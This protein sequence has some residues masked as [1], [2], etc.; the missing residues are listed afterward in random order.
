MNQKKRAH[1]VVHTHWD[2]SWYWPMERFRVKLVSC[3]KAVVQELRQN[4]DYQFTFDGQVLM[5]ED[6][7]EVCPEDGETLRQAAR[8]GRIR[9]GPLYCLA[10]VY[11]TGGEALIRNLL[12]GKEWCT[13]FG[14]GY[15]R[16]LHM[17]DTFG[18]TPSM[19]MIAAGF[20]MTAFS[21]MR[22]VAGQVPE[23][24]SMREVATG[25]AQIPE[26]TRFFIWRCRDGSEVV[27]I[28]FRHGY[29]SAAAIRHYDP[30][31]GEIRSADYV[32]RLR[33]A[34][35]EW[36]DPAHPVVLLMAGTDHMVPWA[37]Q[38][39]AMGEASREGAYEFTF[40]NLDE[41]AEELR[42][43]DLNALPRYLG[44]F[45]G[46]GAAS[47]LGGTLSARP[48]LKQKNAEV[49][50]ILVH[51]VEPGAA[52]ARL[53][54]RPDESCSLIRQAWKILL[55]THPHDDIC[56]CS[57]DAVHR[58]NESDL[59][60]ARQCADAIRRQVFLQIA[61]HYG[62]N[63]A[64][65]TRPSFGL[66]NFQAREHTGP[67]RLR[68]D[69][70]GMVNWGDLTLPPAYRVVD[71]SGFA[72]PFREVWRG[73]SDEHPRQA[74]DLEVYA[75]LP[76]FAFRRF[77]LEPMGGPMAPPLFRRD[78][79]PLAA[80]NG[81]LEV[82]LH[83]NGTFDLSDL[84][85]GRQAHRL[86][87]LSSQGDIGDS[88]D[89]S[90][91]PEEAEWRHE[92]LAWT[93]SRREWPGGVVELQAAG[94]IELPAWTDAA[95]RTRSKDKVTLPFTQ[96]LILAP[97]ARQLEVRLEFTNTVADYRLR[98]NLSLPPGTRHSL[99]GLKFNTV[100]RPAGSPPSGTTAPR[101]FPEHPADH[102]VAAHT[103]A[104]FSRFP[105]NYELVTD[106][107]GRQR[108]ALTILR[109]FS[110]LTNPH[111]GA[112]R[113]GTHAGP[114]T[115]TPEGRC[116]GRHFRLAFGLC[117]L[118]SADALDDVFQ[119]ALQWRAHPLAGQ[120]DATAPFPWRQADGAPDAP[121]PIQ[122]EGPVVVSAFKPASTGR[123]AVLRL[124]NPS[125]QACNAVVSA[126]D[127][128]SLHPASLDEAPLA[129]PA[130][131]GVCRLT[132][133]PMGLATILL[134]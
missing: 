36:D 49:E 123:G 24:H 50:Q 118:P 122:I 99:A 23:P 71:D 16:V 102:F 58:Q 113:P 83:P 43:T 100:Q 39:A 12:I 65:D 97:G 37:G 26:G 77:Y 109:S 34:A 85:T 114:H 76:P 80:S 27:T 112:T 42:R 95:S 2:R 69:F 47:V 15:S 132:V 91:I 64:G 61:R 32:E 101:I 3:V 104:A 67:S 45:H 117:L 63:A 133:P 10:D 127:W 14:G 110:Y 20:G 103:V 51:Q 120:C 107:D 59:E 52:L 46:A 90:D 55:T 30:T 129:E 79:L 124:L 74:V 92:D 33:Q 125:L 44:E 31:L 81:H 1:V 29:G 68:L 60:R 54:G 88:Y 19:P 66:M 48:Y 131:R 108:L 72:V 11:C 21:F 38:A 130:T 57:V 89:Y 121:A 7:L 22:G 4:P 128:L 62:M 84:R 40:S 126:P 105:F 18:I 119:R 86:G 17:P 111:Q 75:P 134:V 53:L 115:R 73:S 9:I 6:Y 94:E 78:S 5:L 116:L 8:D 13:T 28:R 56:G 96:T 70:E 25:E 35:A 106:P 93:L 82:T 41:V 98:W 87:F